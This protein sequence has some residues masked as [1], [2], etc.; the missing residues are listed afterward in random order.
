MCNNRQGDVLS[1]L[2]SY[3]HK[4]VREKRVSENERQEGRKLSERRKEE[5]VT[6]ER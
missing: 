4:R 2:L 5:G 3:E 6:E 1:L